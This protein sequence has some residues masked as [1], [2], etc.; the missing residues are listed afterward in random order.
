MPTVFYPSYRHLGPQLSEMKKV[1]ER[2]MQ[3]ELISSLIDD[4][5]QLKCGP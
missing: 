3:D 2:M 5:A 1:V 4:L